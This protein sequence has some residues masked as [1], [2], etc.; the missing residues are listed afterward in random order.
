[1]VANFDC[2]CTSEL[3]HEDPANVSYDSDLEDSVHFVMPEADTKPPEAEL[4]QQPKRRRLSEIGLRTWDRLDI[5]PIA[6]EFPMKAESAFSECGVNM[7]PKQR[8]RGIHRARSFSGNITH[9]STPPNSLL[10]RGFSTSNFKTP[11]LNRTRSFSGA[12]TCSPL[13]EERFNTSLNSLLGSPS[14]NNSLSENPIFD[15]LKSTLFSDCTSS[16]CPSSLLEALSGGPKQDVYAR[17][18]NLQSK[19]SSL[20]SKYQEEVRELS[21]FYRCQSAEVETERFRELHGD[22]LP[23]SFRNHLNQYYDSQLHMIMERVEKSLQLLTV[24]NRDIVTINRSFRPRPLLS[25]K[26]VNMMEEWYTRNYEHPYPSQTAVD[27]LANAGEIYPEQVK[28]WFAN[29]RNRS[30]NTLPIT[31]VANKKR[32]RQFSSRW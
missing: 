29:K 26:A 22:N 1:M 9:R 20:Q 3:K 11:T 5:P 19:F 21:C 12:A 13:D 10:N 31:E 28:K 6:E 8:Q 24:A 27:A 15:D 32:K 16:N 2:I 18:R 30:K 17:E 25:R 23:R 7:P 14:D 4:A